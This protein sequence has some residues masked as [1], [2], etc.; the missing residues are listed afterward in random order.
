MRQIVNVVG[1]NGVLIQ[2]AA[3]A[4]ADA[5]IL[6]RLQKC[7]GDRQAVHL[8]PQAVDHVHRRSLAHIAL[9]GSSL[10]FAQRL[11]RNEHEAAGCRRRCR[12]SRGPQPDRP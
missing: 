10:H 3:A 7:R 4:S 9:R 6:R 5:Q 8:G 1:L 11:E 2:R 12:H